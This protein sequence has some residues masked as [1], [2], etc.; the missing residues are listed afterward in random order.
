[1]RKI[2]KSYYT[3]LATAL[4]L[5]FSVCG[6]A[7]HKEVEKKAPK[8]AKD[9]LHQAAKNAVHTAVKKGFTTHIHS[10]KD[11]LHFKRSVAEKHALVLSDSALNAIGIDSLLDKVE[12]VH[13]TLNQINNNNATGFNTRDIEGGL[14]DV[15]SNIDLIGDNISLYNTVLDVKNLQM[16]NVLLGDLQGQLSDWREKLFK[17]NKEL[18]NESADMAAY[19]KDTVLR[20]LLSDSAFKSLYADEITDL[21]DKWK[22][23][24]LAL[25]KSRTRINQLQAGVSNQYFETID[26][27]NNINDLLRKISIKSLGKEYDFLWNIGSSTIGEDEDAKELIRQSY[28]GQGKILK[29]YFYRNWD[30]QFWML[31]VGLTVFLWILR[32][33]IMH[34]RNTAINSAVVTEADNDADKK[35]K[36]YHFISKV[37]ILATLVVVFT[38]S[39]F[40]DIHPPTAYV[41]ITEFFMVVVLTCLLWKNWPRRLFYYWLVTSILFIILSITGTFLVPSLGFRLF[42]FGLNIF[43][44]LFGISWFRQLKKYQLPFEKLIKWVL[45]IYSL[46]NLAA[47]VCNTLGRLS[48]TKIFSVTAIF[49]LTQIISLSIFIQILIEAFRLQT[50]VNQ[51]KG[52]FAAKLN[53]SKIDRL[54]CRTLTIV[55]VILWIIVF[56]INL[57]IYNILFDKLGSLLNTPR[58]IGSTTF[59]IGHLLLFVAIIYISNLLQQGIGSLYGRNENNWDP[60]VKKNGSRLAMTR[61]ILIII[62]FM[63]A[64]AASGLPLDKITIVL[65][66]LGVGIG[67]GLQSI[68]NNLVSGVILIFEQPFRIGDYIEIGDKRGRVLDI[69]IRSSKLVMEEGAELIMPN[70]DLLSGRVI[71]WTLRDDSVRIDVPI[72]VEQGHTFEEVKQLILDILATNKHVVQ[73]PPPDILYLGLKDK[74]MNINIQVWID[75][76][77]IVQSIRSEMLNTLNNEL[78]AK[79]VKVV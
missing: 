74:N 22:Q 52:G 10:F 57:N 67:L 78:D 75:D 49:G 50:S 41:E 71:N 4:L 68:V 18:S 24:K 21:K 47:I 2:N 1:M 77:H 61:L 48:L 58:K 60:E 13:N 38:V 29:Y 43:S 54:L 44:V 46:L 76:V 70:A 51:S 36:P 12:D 35:Q 62:G 53:F 14:P 30:N 33:F 63:I 5:L 65:G 56:T 32:N 25:D 9:T 69:G 20:S 59:Q 7:Q 28:Q 37:S 6:Y 73:T 55:A 17:F 66:A 23:A 40:F 11:T 79:G 45:I 72:S 26:L 31:I 3:F 8:E 15:D 19:R 27:Q 34:G 16:F 39:P 64:V 42:L